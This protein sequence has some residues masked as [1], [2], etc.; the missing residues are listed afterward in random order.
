MILTVYSLQY[1]VYSVQYTVYSVQYPVYS[2][3]YTAYS[4]QYTAYSVHLKVC[5]TACRPVPA[6]SSSGQEVGAA[7][8]RHQ[9]KLC[10]LYTVHGTLY[11]WHFFIIAMS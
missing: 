7:A 8:A 2:V 4:E 5:S 3:Q 11:T 1:T 10:T 6:V 9:V